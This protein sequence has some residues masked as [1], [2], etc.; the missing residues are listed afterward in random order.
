MLQTLN[1]QKKKKP[2]ADDS[3]DISLCLFTLG[4]FK[5]CVRG[6]L[7][8]CSLRSLHKIVNIFIS[9]GC[10]VEH[11]KCCNKMDTK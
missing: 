6:V 2:T 10:K 1:S 3:I 4:K 11:I 5:V 8:W 9:Q 7:W